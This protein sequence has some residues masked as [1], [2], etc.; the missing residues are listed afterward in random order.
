MV[1]M[2]TAVQQPLGEH[3]LQ[4]QDLEHSARH[5][6]QWYDAQQQQHQQ[7]TLHQQQQQQHC[8]ADDATDA[9]FKGSANYFSQVQCA[10][11]GALRI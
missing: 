6:S 4:D 11:Q 1:V 5:Q 9:Y 3:P 10:Y 2:E 8:Q 7:T